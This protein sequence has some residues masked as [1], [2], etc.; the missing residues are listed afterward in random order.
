MHARFKL[1]HGA[2]GEIVGRS[3]E[4]SDSGL[5]VEVFPVPKLPNGSNIKMYML[6]SA[7]PHIAFNMKVIRIASDGI[8]LMFVDYEIDGERFS[9]ETLR[10]Q[11]K[12]NLN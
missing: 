1:T 5:F 8:G 7:Y 11:V 10:D 2:I 6:D 3:R 12:K 4:I 9:M